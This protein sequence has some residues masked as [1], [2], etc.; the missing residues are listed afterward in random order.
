MS[1]YYVRRTARV[2]ATIF[3]VAT[4]TFGLI[5]L[6]PGGPFT[7]LRAQLLRQGV[8]ASEVDARISNLQNIDP[9]APLWRQYLDYMGAV[10]Q[11]NFG[12]SISLG[13]PVAQIIA[14]AVPWTV[15]VVLV[16]TILM[17]A[18]G[19]FLGSLQAYWEGSRFDK[20]FSGLSIGLMSV[21]FYVVAVISLYVFAYQWG[22]LPTAGTVGTNVEKELSVPFVLSALEHSL[23]PIFSYTLGGI[24][25]QALAMRGNSIQV[26]GNDYVRVARLRGLPDRRIA[27]RYVARNAI[28]PMYTGFLL[29][30]G[31]R[32][33]GTV[34]LEQIF[35]Y[36]GL[37]Y[38]M[39]AAL[40]AN[41]YPLMMATFLI[42]TVALIVGVYIADLTYSKIDPRISAG[43]SDE[44]Y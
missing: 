20:A 43:G 15:F 8:P 1:N 19:I 10:A 3:A 12:E 38:Y 4:L 2:F 27:T 25:G 24:G 30:L 39:F 32:L 36:T 14:E 17:F 9:N 7:Q 37:G 29:L 26:L 18:V 13:E 33:S 31:F 35:S 6:L 22:W 42:I 5:R 23:L 16:S 41:D 21:P 40:K 34:I 28:L 44:A 11:G